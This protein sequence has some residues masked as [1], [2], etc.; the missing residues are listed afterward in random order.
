MFVEGKSVLLLFFIDGYVYFGN[1]AGYINSSRGLGLTAV[2]AIWEEKVCSYY[3]MSVK[4]DLW[5]CIIVFRTI[6]KGEKIFIDYSWY[7]EEELQRKSAKVV[8]VSEEEVAAQLRM[9]KLQRV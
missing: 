4:Y 8:R 2:N 9:L 5:V 7:K 6:E 1:A 3:Y